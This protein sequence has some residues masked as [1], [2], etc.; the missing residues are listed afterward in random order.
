MSVFLLMFRCFLAELAAL[1]A[2]QKLKYF[3]YLQS[4]I[5]ADPDSTYGF[6]VNSKFPGAGARI[7]P[8]NAQEFVP[9]ALVNGLWVTGYCTMNVHAAGIW[10]TVPRR[11][12]KFAAYQDVLLF[13]FLWGICSS[14]EAEIRLDGLYPV[15]GG[16]AGILS[17][18]TVSA[19]LRYQ[20]P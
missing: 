7:R 16:G 14:S 9:D 19:K 1:H 8:V 6:A 4:P 5:Y 20:L 3:S 10:V 2:W 13:N 18:W 15:Y 11:W 12:G 17:Q